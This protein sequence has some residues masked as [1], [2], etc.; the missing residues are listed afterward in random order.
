V[1]QRL[2]SAPLQLGVEGA[3]VEP[4]FGRLSAGYYAVLEVE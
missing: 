2:P 3:N 1:V 4:G